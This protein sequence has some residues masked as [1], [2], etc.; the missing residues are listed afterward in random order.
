[1]G[2][3]HIKNGEKINLF[4]LNDELPKD[5]TF[6]LIK[7]ESLEV[8]RLAIPG[9]KDVPQHSVRGEITVQCLSGELVFSIENTKR[10]LRPGDWLYLAASEKHSLSAI[11]DCV[12]LVT[13]FLP[14]TA[15]EKQVL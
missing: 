15:H 7:T 13:I 5:K 2:L 6:A 11:T 9:G 1:M 12:V 14:T 3:P 4:E 8:I 10:E